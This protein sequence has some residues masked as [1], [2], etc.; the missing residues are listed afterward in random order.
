MVNELG[1]PKP[2]LLSLYFPISGCPTNLA[3]KLFKITLAL[4]PLSLLHGIAEF[5]SREFVPQSL[6]GGQVCLRN[7]LDICKVNK[8]P[9]FRFC[10]RYLNQC[11]PSELG[12]NNMSASVLAVAVSRTVRSRDV[13]DPLLPIVQSPTWLP[14][15]R[16]PFHSHWVSW[17]E[18]HHRSRLRYL[19]HW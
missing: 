2:A 12:Y 17:L 7:V 16:S 1:G 13:P 8:V 4:L 15:E 10:T 14:M 19:V 3:A 11:V 18:P 6:D 9:S 5:S